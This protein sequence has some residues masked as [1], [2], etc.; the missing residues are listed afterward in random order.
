MTIQFQESAAAP[1]ACE[2]R[3]EQFYA[4][5][6]RDLTLAGIPFLLAGTYAVA[7]YT[8]ISRKTK[9]IDIFCK[10]EDYPRILAL[11]R[12]L[13]YYTE[14]EDPHWIAK[15]WKG[16][17]FFDVI[18]ASSNRAVPITDGWFEDARSTEVLGTVA[19]MVGPTELVWSKVFVQ[20]RDRYDGADVA[21]LILKLRDEIDWRRLLTYMEGYWEV[22]MSHLIHF[23]WIY[24]TERDAVP[25]WVMDELVQRLQS[26]FDLPPSTERVCRGRMLSKADYELDV[27]EWGFADPL[28]EYPK[29]EH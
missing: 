17:H 29:D 18:F 10:P 11:F 5:A 28:G 27:S 13:G 16:K 23:R 6:L 15:V 14:V 24:P 3:A 26:D 25:R 19:K 12:S 7:A 1:I 22:L 9:D 8:G 20:N 2:P 4:D 21:H